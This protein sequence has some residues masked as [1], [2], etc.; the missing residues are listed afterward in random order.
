ME[1]ELRTLTAPAPGAGCP[2]DALVRR[3]LVDGPFATGS[4][5]RLGEVGL[6]LLD[7]PYA[8]HV[9]VALRADMAETGVRRR[10]EP[11]RLEH[12]P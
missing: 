4:R 7:N 12:G 5:R 10:P 6:Q 1:H 2:S 9:A 8:A 11:R 3:A